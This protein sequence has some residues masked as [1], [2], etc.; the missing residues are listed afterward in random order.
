[1]RRNSLLTL[2]RYHLR[3]GTPVPEGQ[4]AYEGANVE[5]AKAQERRGKVAKNAG[6]KALQGMVTI[7]VLEEHAWAHERLQK[8]LEEEGHITKATFTSWE[9]GFKDNDGEASSIPLNGARFEVHFDSEPQWPPVTRIEGKRLPKKEAKTRPDG[10][11]RAVILP[12]L[13]LPFVDE[14]ALSIATQIIQDVKPDQII[15]IGDTLDLS[16]WGRFVQRPE[17]AEATRQSFEQFYQLLYGLRA[18]NR[19]AEIIVL[20]GNHE[21][22]MQR[23][24][25]LN[26][27][28]AYGLKKVTDPEGWPVMSV[29][30][31]CDFESLDIEYIPG[32]PANRYW[33]NERLQ[34]IHGDLARPNG[35]SARAV[36]N[37]ERVSTIFG[38][39]HRRESATV[40]SQ[41]YHGGKQHQTYNIGCLAR[42]DGA[43]PSG[44]TGYDTRTG[45]SVQNFMDWQHGLMVVDYQPGNAPFHAQ[46]VEINTFDGYHTRF[47]GKTYA[48]HGV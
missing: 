15:F 23:D 42:L 48:P 47:N 22:R 39:T 35:K 27:K 21:E 40:T 10:G 2:K 1:M 6:S 9:M 25:L 20:E 19:T 29:P 46:Q 44:K 24:L 34:I 5:H 45:K 18:A 16:S 43:V 31:I 7:Q 36:V 28:A 11:K 38:H 13:Q 14:Q 33:L 12:D 30:N 8:H 26:A 41:D 32:Y 4:E 37:R 3:K 17:F